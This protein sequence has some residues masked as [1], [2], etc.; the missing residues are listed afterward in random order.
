MV[1]RVGAVVLAVLVLSGALAPAVAGEDA[2]PGPRLVVVGDS[3][4]LG[5]RSDVVGALAHWDLAFDAEVGRTTSQGLEVLRS[6]DAGR[7]DVVVVELGANDAGSPVLFA[8]R[9]RAVLAELAAV[10]HVI[11]LTVPEIEPFYVESN[12]LLRAEAEIRPGL[13]VA[14][15]GAVSQA[16]PGA[17]ADGLHLRAPGREAITDLVVFHV[18]AARR[19]LEVEALV[20][21]L[22]ASAFW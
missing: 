12:A 5:A 1:R 14:E 18:E 21:R 3:I 15:W 2:E 13:A 19:R 16:T 9:M 6:L 17:T 10:P 8:T 20:A 7:A 22:R 4:V 11:W